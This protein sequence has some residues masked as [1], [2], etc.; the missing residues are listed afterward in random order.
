ME[1]VGTGSCCPTGQSMQGH[2][3]VSFQTLWLLPLTVL[4]P[5][6]PALAVSVQ[7]LSAFLLD[8]GRGGSPFT[9]P[10]FSVLSCAAGTGMLRPFALSFGVV[11]G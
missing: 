6:W 1:S 9:F 2:P 7:L 11:L 8:W 3:Q 10:V 5:P 4:V